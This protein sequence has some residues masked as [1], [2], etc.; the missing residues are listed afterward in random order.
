MFEN[1]F[2]RSRIN[3]SVSW[4]RFHWECKDCA[5]RV[6]KR[7]TWL[8]KTLV[9]SWFVLDSES[10]ESPRP[11][12]LSPG[13]VAALSNIFPR[14]PAWLYLRLHKSYVHITHI[15]PTKT[16]ILSFWM[17]ETD[18]MV[19]ITLPAVNDKVYNLKLLKGRERVAR[20]LSWAP[21]VK[22]CSLRSDTD[23]ESS[24]STWL[25]VYILFRWSQMSV[26]IR[27]AKMRLIRQFNYKCL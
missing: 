21:S 1:D 18:A 2:R 25:W 8:G 14:L 11:S 26:M 23:K 15:H 16:I 17:P 24:S 3:E 6:V 19:R 13:T 27:S 7:C 5:M 22:I 12:G 10:S 20:H 9:P 4:N